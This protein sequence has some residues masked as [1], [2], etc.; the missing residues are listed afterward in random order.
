MFFSFL[1]ANAQND[2]TTDEVETIN[3]VL[4]KNKRAF[5]GTLYRDSPNINNTCM[6][7]LEASYLNGYLNGVKNEYSEN[8]KI[9]FTGKFTNGKEIGEHF[10]YDDL[11]NIEMRI[12][13]SSVEVKES[14]GQNTVVETKTE[15]LPIIDTQSKPNEQ[16][17]SILEV[18]TAAGFE[19]KTENVP[20]IVLETKPI[21]QFET[22]TEIN[23]QTAFEVKTENVP[24]IISE[25][26]PVEQ[27]EINSEINPQ[28][29]FE[30]KTESLPVINTETGPKI[31]TETSSYTNNI[32]NIQP[33]SNEYE[34]SYWSE[35]T[36]VPPTAPG[37]EG[38]TEIPLANCTNNAV[39]NFILSNIDKHTLGLQGLPK[40]KYTVLVKF[41]ISKKGSIRDIVIQSPLIQLE[42]EFIRILKLLPNFRPGQLNGAYVRVKYEFGLNVTL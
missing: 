15:S 18:N 4:Y 42:N 34:P 24:V 16:V 1:A 13:F 11:G 36:D 17:E 23:T 7:V 37:C 5:T 8:G 12:L 9:K 32:N 26:E 41:N 31:N 10:F 22:N 2:A 21:E 30:V 39:Y 38:L 29:G 33:E 14:K 40:G 27:I 3:G 19:T 6:C 35:M 28:T 25:T 20:I